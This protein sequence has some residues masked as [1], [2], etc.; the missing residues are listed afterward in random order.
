MQE[1]SKSYAYSLPRHFRYVILI[2]TKVSES[3]LR[4]IFVA[5]LHIWGGRYNPIIPVEEDKI[6][7]EWMATIQHYDPDIIFFNNGINIEEIKKSFFYQAR[8]YQEL[9]DDR[10]PYFPG[11]NI[12]NILHQEVDGK[13]IREGSLKLMHTVESYKF[14][15][16]TLDFYRL[17]LGLLHLYQGED[18][19]LKNYETRII[20]KEAS[21]TILETIVTF[22]PF[23]KSLLSSLFLNTTVLETNRHPELYKIEIILYD[24]SNYLKDL[25]YFWNRQR[26]LKPTLEL[27]QIIVSK[28]QLDELLNN[29]NL[30][31]LLYRINYTRRFSLVSRTLNEGELKVYQSHLQELCP[32]CEISYLAIDKFPFEVRKTNFFITDKINK[33]KHLIIGNSDNIQIVE[34]IFSAQKNKI[35]D[36][37]VVDIELERDAVNEHRFLKFPYNTPL[38]FLVTQQKS[39]IN[40]YHRVS[41]LLD[42]NN[43]QI[44][45]GLP[46]DNNVI[47]TLLLHRE[48]EGKLI[49]IPCEVFN[50][51]KAGQKLSAFLNLFDDNWET[52]DQFISDQFWLDIF[53][54]DSQL[55][56]SAIRTGKG[57]FSYQ[58]LQKELQMLYKKFHS[59]FKSRIEKPEGKTLTNEYLDALTKKYIKDDF[60]SYIDDGLQFMIKRKGVFIGMKVNCH[61][62]GANKWYSLAELNDSIE[63]KGCY[64]II[65][66]GLKSFV[67]FK[68]SETII[69]NLLSDQTKNSKTYDGNYVVIRTLNALKKDF[70]N[71]YSSFM[72]V[73]PV[74]IIYHEQ[75]KKYETDIDI[76]AIQEGRLI[77]GEA[78]NNA[79][80]FNRK[81]I[82][83]L[84]WV[85]NNLFPDEIVL[86][87]SKGKL[88]DQIERIK[89]GIRNPECQVV[90]M[91]ASKPWYRFQGLFGLTKDD[92]KS[93]NLNSE[94]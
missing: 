90:S 71:C 26:Y 47:T 25:L 38:H 42:D 4:K 11:V 57:I 9:L 27:Q 16:S 69:S 48:V 3:F 31:W 17:N 68:L 46:T 66:P 34:P 77:L 14:D 41:L 28:S 70:K 60:E 92:E 10:T 80:E 23:F 72:W 85:G 50:I 55:R 5:N 56:E 82:D 86:A 43:R 35:D 89:K 65:I 44:N 6:S 40:R 63:C 18:I 22:N 29:Q 8:E 2:S 36:P 83:F 91:K 74:G 54:S 58:D 13:I 19:F 94:S 39:R 45:I 32:Q 61:H 84:I 81:E 93:S 53:T 7:E 15:L 30:E 88:T 1:P 79:K 49:N 87:Y 24:E 21:S 62:C 59:E 20:D 73:P 67:Y 37:F 76:I 78:K 12:H 52:V 33:V 51:N 64:S 75:S